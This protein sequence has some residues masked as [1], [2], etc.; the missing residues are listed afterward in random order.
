[1][2]APAQHQHRLRDRTSMQSA[3][4]RASAGSRGRG[5]GYGVLPTPDPTIASCI[6]DEDVAL[7][8]MRL[9]EASNISYGR[10][11]ASTMDETM[12]GQADV[13][14]SAT[15]DS[16]GESDTPNQRSLPPFESKPGFNRDAAN[17]QDHTKGPIPSSSSFEP[18]GD[19]DGD[20]H[21]GRL[22]DQHNSAIAKS[23][24]THKQLPKVR[25][26]GIKK[27]SKASK[28]KS[29]AMKKPKTPMTSAPKVSMSPTSMVSLSRKG[30]ASTLNFQHHLGI[31][32]EDLSTKPRCQRCR[33]SKKG[34]DRQRPCQRC[35]DAGIG[36]DGCV[37]ED[38][39]NGRKG[40]FGRH[41]GVTVRREANS[42]E[43][44]AVP[45][46]QE[47]TDNLVDG[48]AASP[49]ERSKKRKRV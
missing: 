3:T 2:P 38:E 30:S 47:A 1:M 16:E 40:R 24:M 33:K 29:T 49:G 35:K 31:D 46:E 5:S 39:G 28:L 18:D 25:T 21:D 34:C 20:Y 7:Q 11:S 48:A 17:L 42:A 12:S 37:S 10:T 41:M 45:Q 6:S 22:Q 19:I 4:G 27:P 13:A 26:D 43:E 44:A 36:I 9:S 15:S 32:E 8:L 14:S 23:K